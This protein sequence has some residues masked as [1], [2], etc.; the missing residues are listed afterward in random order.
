LGTSLTPASAAAIHD[1]LNALKP[2]D[3]LKA[4][5]CFVAI[6]HHNV[7]PESD[8][9]QHDAMWVKCR[10]T[11][12]I[13]SLAAAYKKH[14]PE[15]AGIVLVHD[16]QVVEERSR[17]QTLAT[18]Q[19]ADFLALEAVLAQDIAKRTTPKASAMRSPLDDI[20]QAVNRQVMNRTPLKGTNMTPERSFA[21]AS[22]PSTKSSLRDIKPKVAHISSTPLQPPGTPLAEVDAGQLAWEDYFFE[23]Q[24]Y[25]RQVVGDESL[26]KQYGDDEDARDKSR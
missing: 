16:F 1:R 23:R 26:S 14:S 10:R 3:T 6:L 7:T 2:T 22:T 19:P 12:E 21:S 20:P 18:R 8:F 13:A 25:Y 11:T 5:H 24:E 15:A 4:G 9:Q 17:V